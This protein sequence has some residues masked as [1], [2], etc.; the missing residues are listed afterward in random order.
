[1][2]VR[3][4]GMHRLLGLGIA[5]LL[6]AA[7]CAP[8][9]RVALAVAPA[10]AVLFVDGEALPAV[11]EAIELRSDRDHKLFFKSPGYRPELVV[12]RSQRVDGAPRLDPQDVRVR[13]T[14]VAP[15]GRDVRIERDAP[16]APTER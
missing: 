3:L 8:T 15:S 6:L 16:A 12:L 1:M 10:G 13:L 14:P 7:G 9:Q 4:S 2:P 11:P 5:G